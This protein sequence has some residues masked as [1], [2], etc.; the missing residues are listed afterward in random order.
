MEPGFAEIYAVELLFAQIPRLDPH[1]LLT[2]LR[3]RCGSVDLI[4]RRDNDTFLIYALMDYPIELDDATLPVQAIISLRPDPL[5]V[6]SYEPALQQTWDWPEARLAVS[7]ACYSVLV[8]ELLGRYLDY[9]PRLRLFQNVIM[10][11]LDF[12]PCTAIY[13]QPCQKIVEPAAYWEAMHD[14]EPASFLTAVNVRL[15]R[16]EGGSPSEVV[17]DTL[18]LAALGLPDL[19]IHYAGLDPGQVGRAL[20]KLAYYLYQNGDV[21]V[22]GQIVPGF[23]DEDRWQSRH[24]MSLIEPRRIVL[25]LNPG[26]PY[27]GLR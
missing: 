21:I 8:T 1:T 23:R 17:M 19:Q 2:S 16:V 20:Y 26:Y 22:D 25:D 5:D 14:G 4:E 9:G 13:W 24:A 12:I 27:A 11:M 10:S 6:T 3:M 7:Q 18:G 15:L